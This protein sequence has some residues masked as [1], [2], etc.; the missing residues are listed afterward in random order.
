M[1]N[2]AIGA[3][4]TKKQGGSNGWLGGGCREEKEIAIK[5]QD[6]YMAPSYSK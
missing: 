2:T 4:E 1:R 3:Q 5:I 6:C